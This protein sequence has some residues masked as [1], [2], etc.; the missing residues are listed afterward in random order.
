[1]A[2]EPLRSPGSCAVLSPQ[3]HASI[4][5]FCHYYILAINVFRFA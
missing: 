2:R 4:G 3:D 5:W 1:M